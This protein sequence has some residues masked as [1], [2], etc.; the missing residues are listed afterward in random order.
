MACMT[1]NELMEAMSNVSSDGSSQL[2]LRSEDLQNRFIVDRIPMLKNGVKKKCLLLLEA[3]IALPFDPETGEANDKFNPHR[4]YRPPFSATTTALAL[5]DAANSNEVL[6]AT[7][8]KRAGL[9]EWDTSDTGT[10]TEEDW[11]IFQ[12]YRVPRIFSLSVTHV[13]IEQM[14]GNSFG[15]DYAVSVQRDSEGNVIGDVPGFLIANKFFRDRNFEELNEYVAWTKTEA[16]KDSEKTIKEHKAK[17]MQNTPVS[18]DRPANFVRLFEI[19]TDNELAISSDVDLAGVTKDS[20]AEFEVLS[21]YKKGI[22]LEIEEY[23]DGGYK[24]FDKFFDF[25]T[26]EMKGPKSGD[27]S[28]ISGKAKIGQDTTFKAPTTPLDDYETYGPNGEKTETLRTALREYIDSNVDLETRVRRSMRVPVYTD[29][30]EDKIF[31][32][33]ASVI[34]LD[35][36]KYITQE[37]LK[38]NRDFIM[39]VFGA[40][41]AGILE[42]ID[43]GVSDREEGALEDEGNEDVKY[44]LASEE[45][46]GED[47][48][49]VLDLADDSDVDFSSD[50]FKA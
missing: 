11:K 27:D 31:Q 10:F 20:I 8:M 28:T 24:K 29:E 21:R 2:N 33:I 25:F 42:E 22:R 5:K 39:A 46:K 7:L 50:D 34:D 40:E 49:S 1:M 19:P 30:V 3:E 43:A 17:I 26:L 47:S 14:T 15:Q 48:V 35:N 37:V 36:D 38:R 41:A 16:C 45:F 4:K 23:M 32:T 6:K 44:D 13:T 9:S 12:K 18:D